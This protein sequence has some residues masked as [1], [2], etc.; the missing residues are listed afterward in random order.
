MLSKTS[1]VDLI[2]VDESCILSVRTATVVS[3][4]GTE[5]SRSYHRTTLPPGSDLEGHDPK[6]IAVA[7]AV[8]TPEV[9]QAYQDQL[10][11][12]PGGES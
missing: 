9:V 11:A 2:S 4:D 7:E 5:L 1:V 12:G 3:E 8:W 6:V 10:A